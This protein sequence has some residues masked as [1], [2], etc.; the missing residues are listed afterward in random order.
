MVD[1]VRQSIDRLA[2]LRSPRPARYAAA[3]LLVGLVA[4]FVELHLTG[5]GHGTHLLVLLMAIVCT[6]LI[7]G[8]GPGAFVRLAGGTGSAAA[9]VGAIGFVSSAPDTLV[10]LMMYLLTGSA[11]LVLVSV[12]IRSAVSRSVS[13]APGPP[14]GGGPIE[15]L[16]TRER[17]VLG[18]AATGMSVD[19]IGRLLFVSPNTVKTHLARAYAKLGAR[20]RAQAVRL[21]IHCGCLTPA[22]ICPHVWG[23][24]TREQSHP[25]G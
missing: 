22:D 23:T 10:Q 8:P 15:A 1:A 17:E 18:L 13:V 2:S 11:F 24:A 7:L 16:T 5:L 3:L 9:S 6:A 12:A 19:Q 4:I 20:N 21:A 14:V 25:I